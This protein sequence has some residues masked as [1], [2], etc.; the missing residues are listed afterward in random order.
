M[1]V[2]KKIALGLASAA[3]GLSLIG[4]GTLSYFSDAA[5]IHNGMAAGTLD[6]AVDHA[7]NFPLN[8][9][10]SN[11][12]PGDSFERQFV[13]KNSGSL[14]IQDVFMS[15][16][17]KVKNHLRTGAT[18]DEFLDALVVDYFVD[19]NDPKFENGYLLINSQ[20]ITLRE[21]IA[22]E[23]DG[24]IIPKYLKGGKLNLAPFGITSN[25]GK[26][27]RIRITF[28]DTGVPQNKLQGMAAKFDFNLDARQEMGT[29]QSQ[30]GP[31]GKLTGSG[32]IGD[33]LKT[34]D[35][36]SHTA[37]QP[38]IYDVAPWRE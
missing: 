14:A 36:N 11:I 26:R 23:F 8:F 2:K 30:V 10:L 5:V 35:E 21:A 20:D 7:W 3:L 37:T 18:A 28:K 25:A 33:G 17:A 15:V 22:G 6:L 31:N 16:T 9:D 19:V 24:K 38:E 12:K 4:G 34:S 27:Y 1:G 29:H 13:L 32:M